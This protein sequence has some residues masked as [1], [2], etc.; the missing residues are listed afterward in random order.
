MSNNKR[1]SKTS[2]HTSS[3]KSSSGG[4]YVRWRNNGP[5]SLNDVTFVDDEGAETVV[6]EW[7][8]MKTV[9]LHEQFTDQASEIGQLEHIGYAQP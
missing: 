6:R 2:V 8:P 4:R 9:S 3:T 5:S 7:T 1:R